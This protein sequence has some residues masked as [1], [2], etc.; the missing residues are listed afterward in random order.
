M[1]PLLDMKSVTL[2]MMWEADLQVL[3]FYHNPIV[4]GNLQFWPGN[5]IPAPW[6]KTSDPKMLMDFLESNYKGRRNRDSFY[7]SQCTLTPDQNT[8][9]MNMNGSLKDFVRNVNSTICEWIKTKP[10]GK[11][12]I[13]ICSMDFVEMSNFIPI[14]VGLN[15]V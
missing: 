4:C 10:A 13:N 6:A 2:S 1:C 3:V 11:H 12:S 5:I 15:K 14:I 8:L 9:M 7:V